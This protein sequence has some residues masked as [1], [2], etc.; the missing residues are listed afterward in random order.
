MT[1]A[2]PLGFESIFGV[3]PCSRCIVQLE[4]CMGLSCTMSELAN[5]RTVVNWLEPAR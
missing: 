3:R 4:S 2:G 5:R 1:E